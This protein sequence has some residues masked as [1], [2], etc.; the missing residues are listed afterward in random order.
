MVRITMQGSSFAS[1]LP[2]FVSRCNKFIL[3]LPLQLCSPS[4][5]SQPIAN[6]IAITCIDEN[7]DVMQQI[8]QLIMEMLH[9]ITCCLESERH[10]RV[11]IS[12]LARS[13]K[14]FLDFLGVEVFVH[15]GEIITELAMLTWDA[16]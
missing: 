8:S 2:F 12:P 9:V 6:V 16:H 7:F 13:S 1:N 15:H 3:V 5:V 11:A 14:L 4:L 10:R